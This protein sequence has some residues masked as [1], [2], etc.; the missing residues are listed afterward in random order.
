MVVDDEGGAIALCTEL[1]CPTG[2]ALSQIVQFDDPGE[3]L[4]EI[5]KLRSP[6]AWAAAVLCRA[7]ARGSV[8]LLS[9]LGEET[10]EMLGVAHIASATEL[11]RLA[12]RF[13]SCTL[14]EGAQHLMPSVVGQGV[15][16]SS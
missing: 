6:D 4:G 11:A 12:S 8:F 2:E 5:L 9:R 3:A 7:L 16:E 14:L 13:D 10:V 15:V 1:D